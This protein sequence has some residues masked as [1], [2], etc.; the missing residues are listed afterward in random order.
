M[1]EKDDSF[2]SLER[3]EIDDSIK[4]PFYYYMITANLFDT[5]PL[6]ATSLSLSGAVA[7]V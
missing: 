7:L 1:Y 6:Q 2:Q 5:A 4:T 3:V